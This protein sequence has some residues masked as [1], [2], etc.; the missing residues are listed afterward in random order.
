M[1]PEE[2]KCTFS[3]Q[4]GPGV[5]ERIAK[6]T[7]M[8]IDQINATFKRFDEMA[9]TRRYL[10]RRMAE[11]KAF[12]TSMDHLQMLIITEKPRELVPRIK[13]ARGRR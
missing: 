12:P 3:T 5:R 9:K 2:R 11:G 4:L 13:P 8:S 1:T 7:N 10:Q 6:E